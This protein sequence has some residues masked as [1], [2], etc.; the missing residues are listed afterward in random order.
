MNDDELG[1]GPERQSGAARP[2]IPIDGHP[3]VPVAAPGAEYF[4]CYGQIVTYETQ[5][6][7][8]GSGTLI[9]AGEGFGILTCAHNLYDEAIA[10]LVERIEFSPGR[11]ATATPYGT[12]SADQ[13]MFHVP[14]QYLANPDDDRYDYAVV[15]VD[16]DQ[17]PAGIGRLVTMES[18]SMAT[19]V[20]VQV[21]GYPN[22]RPTHPY[23]TMCYSR[24]VTLTNPATSGVVRYNASSQPRSSGSAVC[25]VLGTGTA[26]APDVAHVNAIHINGVGTGP[27]SPYN[28]AVYLTSDI[29]R[30]VAEQVNG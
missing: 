5:G 12:I 25:R 17:V 30:W 14:A 13:D 23:P 4:R 19:Q 2:A 3:I 15:R 26:E 18:V 27:G 24:G 16:R 22:N 21:T 10:D 20:A 28:E 1:R 29:I 11:T 9:A 6:P 7:G 8:Y